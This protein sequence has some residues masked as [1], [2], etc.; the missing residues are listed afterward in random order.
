GRCV[1][2][3]ASNRSA[4]CATAPGAGR[5]R[6]ASRRGPGSSCTSGDVI[7][8]RSNRGKGGHP[9]RGRGR[10]GGATSGV[11]G[12][13]AGLRAR[14]AAIVLDGEDVAV[15]RRGPLLALHRHIE[16]A[17]RLTNVFLDLAP[18][19]LR[20]ALDHIRG[21]VVAEL[22]G[23]TVFDEFIIERVYLAKV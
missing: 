4:R 15:K 21:R 19:E 1:T 2:H 10:G 8:D 22:F 3:A 5:W 23:N 7:R 16:I 17:Q 9:S 6:R 11:V 14:P 13:C 12:G 18:E 20:V